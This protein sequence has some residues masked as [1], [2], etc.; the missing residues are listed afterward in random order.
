MN[1][2]ENSTTIID[3]YSDLNHL[4]FLET[5]KT[6]CNKIYCFLGYLLT[7]WDKM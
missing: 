6:F 4:T 3:V 1:P 7:F 2:Y 5:K